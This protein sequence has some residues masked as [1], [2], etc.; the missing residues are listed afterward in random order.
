MTHRK[1]QRD[2]EKEGNK[3]KIGDHHY[4]TVLFIH[5]SLQQ[6]FH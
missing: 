3:T 5:P 1:K 6:H 2:K 4:M